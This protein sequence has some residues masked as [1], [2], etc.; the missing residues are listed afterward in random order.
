MNGNGFKT[1]VVDP[2]K[3]AVTSEP[4][5]GTL[6]TEAFETIRDTERLSGFGRFATKMQSVFQTSKPSQSKRES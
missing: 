5:E 6:T 3:V 1:S 4:A 2:E